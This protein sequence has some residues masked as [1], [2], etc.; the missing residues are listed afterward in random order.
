[1]VRK[2]KFQ[3]RKKQNKP[4]EENSK[5]IQNQNPNKLQKKNGNSPWDL[6]RVTTQSS[7]KEMWLLMY[8]SILSQSIQKIK[9]DIKE[10]QKTRWWGFSTI[11]SQ[12]SGWKIQKQKTAIWNWQKPFQK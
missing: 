10:S 4:K 11:Q 2:R 8:I 6:L 3:K 1:M 9:K 7:V 12:T 5:Q